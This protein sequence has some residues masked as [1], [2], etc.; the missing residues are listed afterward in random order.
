MIDL[1][2]DQE[3]PISRGQIAEELDWDPVK[4]SHVLKVLLKWDDI[5]CIEVDRYKAQKMLGTKKAHR[6]MRFYYLE[7]KKE[8]SCSSS[9]S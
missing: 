7:M 1:L 8:S 9:K 5:Q 4:V 2:R 6:R 3:K